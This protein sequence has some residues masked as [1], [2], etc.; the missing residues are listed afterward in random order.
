MLIILKSVP[1]PARGRIFKKALKFVEVKIASKAVGDWSAVENWL[2]VV[3]S[4]SDRLKQQLSV[5]LISNIDDKFSDCIDE[6][7]M[8]GGN[9][10]EI[11]KLLAKLIL[12]KVDLIVPKSLI[13][14]W[15]Q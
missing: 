10:V 15:K 13:Q 2:H 6:F 8:T 3:R 14:V 11:L 4:H 5:D 12:V 7:E 1:I 9:E